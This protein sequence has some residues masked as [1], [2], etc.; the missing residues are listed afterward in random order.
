MG[1][2]RHDAMTSSLIITA[3]K[4]DIASHGKIVA[5]SII[6]VKIV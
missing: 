3:S 6:T 5:L 4:V 1:A 2:P